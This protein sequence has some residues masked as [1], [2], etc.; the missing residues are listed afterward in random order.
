MTA[1]VTKDSGER[2]I[3]P[4]GMQRDSAKKELQ[5]D[6]IPMPMLVRWAELM[7]RGAEKY[8]ARNWEKAATE[9]ELARAYE[10]AFRHFVQ[11]RRGDTDEDHAAAI[12]FNIGLAEHIKARSAAVPPK[13]KVLGVGARIR[14]RNSSCAHDGAEGVVDRNDGEGEGQSPWWVALDGALYET[15]FDARDLEVIG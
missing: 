2:Q 4:T 11:W 5:P 1:F 8:G 12:Y 10:S 15:C 13:V 3:F 14:V 6:L 9:E 7:G